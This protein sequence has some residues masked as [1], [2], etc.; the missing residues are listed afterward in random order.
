MKIKFIPENEKSS[1]IERR[2]DEKRYGLGGWK[3]KREKNVS[4]HLLNQM[5]QKFWQAP[6]Y[7]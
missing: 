2:H 6:E 5:A 4:E 7:D 3:E 1:G